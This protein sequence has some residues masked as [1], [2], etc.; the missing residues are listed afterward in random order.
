MP[1]IPS[2][3]FGV[4]NR[5]ALFLVGGFVLS[6]G[7]VTGAVLGAEK[8]VALPQWIIERMQ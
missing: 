7:A 5:D 1:S 2:E 3:R 6:V 8:P 4:I